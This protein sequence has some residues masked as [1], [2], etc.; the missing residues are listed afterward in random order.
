MKKR[1]TTSRCHILLRLGLS[2]QIKL[3]LNNVKRM[4]CFTLLNINISIKKHAHIHLSWDTESRLLYSRPE[5][6]NLE[7]H[8]SSR[9]W[10]VWWLGETST[11]MGTNTEL[12]HTLEEI[13]R[14][15]DTFQENS[16]ASKWFKVSLPSTKNLKFGE[17]ISLD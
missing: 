4:L 3:Y 1:C 14:R 7:K 17:E 11:P 8:F 5:I 13:Q 6:L 9:F 16:H 15:C 10:T 2:H 12:K